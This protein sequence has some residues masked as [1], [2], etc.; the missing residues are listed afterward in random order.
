MQAPTIRQDLRSLTV[1]LN[2]LHILYEIIL[3]VDG[4]IDNTAELVRSESDLSHIRIEVLSSNYGKG[5][6]LKHGF[7]Q[8][9]GTIIGFID[10]G[11]DIDYS[12]LP[13]M[14]DLMN[15]S[16]ADIV[17]GSKR[18]ALSVITYPRIRR[19]Y[20][21][22]YQIINQILFRLHIKD[23]QVGA[24]LFRNHVIQT[25]LPH[26]QINRFAFDLELLVLARY[27][28]YSH[29]V[30]SPI[31]IRHAFQST[32]NLYS[33]FEMFVDTIR[34]YFREK[35]LVS[36]QLSSGIAIDIHKPSVKT[37]KKEYIRE[38]IK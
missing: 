3:V 28:Q 26:I 17:I 13:V 4:N 33:V 14:L 36:N 21:F 12:C 31:K 2:R 18:H 20:S 25:I 22:V 15:F 8:A 6:A 38:K 32:I 10:A 9:R 30:E 27:Y 5:Y 35:N 1:I 34:L 11:G 19:F 37:N 24:K 29:I 23:T 7:S 16:N